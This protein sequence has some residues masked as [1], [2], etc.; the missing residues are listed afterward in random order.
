MSNDKIKKKLKANQL[1]SRTNLALKNYDLDLE[2]EIFN[3]SNDD[4]INSTIDLQKFNSFYKQKSKS[5]TN[6]IKNVFRNESCGKICDKKKN[7]NFDSISNYRT[8]ELSWSVKYMAM[9]NQF[10]NSTIE[11]VENNKYKALNKE[12]YL[13]NLINA[14]YMKIR[15]FEK[16][17]FINSMSLIIFTYLCI[18]LI[19]ST[20]HGIL[21]NNKNK[22]QKSSS[23]NKFIQFLPPKDFIVSFKHY[24]SDIFTHS[25]HFLF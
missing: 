1:E 20:V 4:H 18:S 16:Y 3:T 11:L 7:L 14:I 17:D 5:S 24:F 10:N 15:K 9:K 23:I 19:E 13:K 6:K 22:T 8:R 21:S 2:Y 25:I 12:N